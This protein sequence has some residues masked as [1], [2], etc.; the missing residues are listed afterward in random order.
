MRRAALAVASLWLAACARNELLVED[1]WI[2]AAPP[3]AASL[4][5]YLVVDNRTDAAITITD[6]SSPYFGHAM[7]H[8]TVIADGVARMVHESSL[9]VDAGAS[10]T[11]APGGRHLMLMAPD[12]PIEEGM[13]VPLTLTLADGRSVGVLAIVRSDR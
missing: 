6:V 11:L 12:R 10:A 4:A 8:A 7:I 9:T 3:G 2:R 13:E 5:A 1:A